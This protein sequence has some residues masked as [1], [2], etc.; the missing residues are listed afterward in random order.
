VA[1]GILHWA[2]SAAFSERLLQIEIDGISST[3][4]QKCILQRRCLF[5]STCDVLYIIFG[6]YAVSFILDTMV[7]EVLGSCMMDVRSWNTVMLKTTAEPGFKATV[8]PISSDGIK[9]FKTDLEINAL[10]T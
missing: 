9:T 3:W 1:I 4:F 10:S 6:F 8:M 2:V 5:E 7:I